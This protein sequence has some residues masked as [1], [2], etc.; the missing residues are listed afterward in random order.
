MLQ[1]RVIPA[2]LL[3]NNGL[4]K[5]TRFKDPKYVGDPINAIRIFRVLRAVKVA[6]YVPY[7]SLMSASAAASA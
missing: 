1:H 6:R 5:T 7:V 3:R 2:L 4:V